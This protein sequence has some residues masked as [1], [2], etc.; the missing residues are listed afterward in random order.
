MAR[1][2]VR[3]IPPL[4][5]AVV[6][7]VTVWLAASGSGRA[8]ERDRYLYFGLAYLRAGAQIQAEDNLTRY[9]AEEPDPRIRQIVSRVLPLLRQPLTQDVRDY[10]AVTLE[11]AVRARLTTLAPSDRPR[12]TDRPRYLSRMFGPL[13]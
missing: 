2:S 13:F 6:V 4:L 3:K 8:A 12:P 1:R 5:C 7:G 9:R 10:I 11:E